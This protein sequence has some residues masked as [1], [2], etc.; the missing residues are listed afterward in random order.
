MIDMK[1][2]RELA[3]AAVFMSGLSLIAA[4]QPIGAVDETFDARLTDVGGPPVWPGVLAM[5][6]ASDG[7]IYIGGHRFSANGVDQ[8]GLTR[9][10][11][12]GSWDT[13]FRAQPSPEFGMD[14][15][16]LLLQPD[17]KIWAGWSSLYRYLANGEYDSEVNKR[18]GGLHLVGIQQDGKLLAG[19]G[20]LRRLHADGI[21]DES[22]KSPAEEHVP[23][24]GRLGALELRDGKI[25][26]VGD[27]KI[28][29]L[30]PDGALDT[31]FG[32]TKADATEIAVDPQS[33]KIYFYGFFT[34]VAGAKSTGLMRLNTDGTL[35]SLFVPPPDLNLQSW[36]APTQI[37]L[38]G[39]GK[40]IVGHN[41]TELDPNGS[42]GRLLR[43]NIDGSLDA[44][45]AFHPGPSYGGPVYEILVQPDDKILVCGAFETVNGISRVGIVRLK[46]TDI[47]EPGT[48]PRL[49]AARID[50]VLRF[51]LSGDPGQAYTIQA[52]GDLRTWTDVGIVTA[53]ADPVPLVDSRDRIPPEA[54][55]YRA[56]VR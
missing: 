56:L 14:A 34:S 27:G 11:P 46:V 50:G 54:Q 1:T 30:H 17:G 13:S 31:S 20:P 47:T 24:W 32:P 28:L 15:H 43:L 8:R 3:A 39:D 37:A 36:G 19:G 23:G 6:L 44:I 40:V 38:Q 55:F 49:Q 22:F 18:I 12:D 21:L 25:L 45:L 26:V 48:P 51:T 41:F 9:L 42:S 10:N 5:A 2:I 33:E 35:D 53:A 4:N 29:R 7:K 52:S 16:H